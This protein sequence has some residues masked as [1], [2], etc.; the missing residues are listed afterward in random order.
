MASFRSGNV[1][2]IVLAVHVGRR[3]NVQ[4]P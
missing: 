2:F 4:A 3:E 1:G